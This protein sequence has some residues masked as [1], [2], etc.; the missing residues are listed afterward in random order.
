[1]LIYTLSTQHGRMGV[2]PM[3]NDADYIT[4]H[5]RVD[6]RAQCVR[7][8]FDVKAHCWCVV[9]GM[10][11]VSGCGCCGRY[12]HRISRLWHIYIKFTRIIYPLKRGPLA[13]RTTHFN[14]VG[15]PLMCVVWLGNTK[16]CW[17]YRFH[18]CIGY[19]RLRSLLLITMQIRK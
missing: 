12:F 10:W 3:C 5:F 18:A 7:S 9:S 13:K 19:V 1:M 16:V 8:C 17:R 6:V 2:C 14:A 11:Y 4:L 15:R